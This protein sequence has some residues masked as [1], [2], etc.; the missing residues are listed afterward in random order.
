MCIKNIGMDKVEWR[1]VD[2]QALFIY[3]EKSDIHKI[4]KSKLEITTIKIIAHLRD[5]FD[6]VILIYFLVTTVKTN[7]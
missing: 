7:S 3:Y 6:T 1:L 4:L 5:V 2:N